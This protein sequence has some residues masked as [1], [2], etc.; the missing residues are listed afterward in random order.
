MHYVTCWVSAV[1]RFAFFD[2][3][4]QWRN[5]QGGALLTGKFLLTYRPTGKTEA[6]KKGKMEQKRMEIEEG[7][8]DISKRKE[9]SEM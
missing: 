4:H 5:R 1:T 8:F 9:K 2:G 7:K 3:I 6:R